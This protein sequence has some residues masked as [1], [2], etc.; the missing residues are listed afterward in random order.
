MTTKTTNSLKTLVNQQSYD[1]RLTT[2]ILEIPIP[3]VLQQ[4]NDN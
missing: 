3:L 4:L 2:Q 1:Y